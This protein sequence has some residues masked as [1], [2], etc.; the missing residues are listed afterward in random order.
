MKRWM[1]ALSLV[2]LASMSHA[3]TQADLILRGVVAPVLDISI[4]NETVASNLDLSQAASN[5]KVATI[6]EKSNYHQ[7][8]KVKVKSTN[9]GKMVNLSDAN[10]FVN[11][12][13]T[14]SGATVPLTAAPSQVY[15]T[16][17][18]RGTF[19]KELK[20]SYAQPTNLSAGTYEDTVQF[21]IEAN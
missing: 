21:T 1:F 2:T 5:I 17:N 13:L 14:Y 11:Y 12:T 16:S 8:Y 7:G 18:L 9:S 3:A 4:A 15:T 10:S 6:T 19:S 20:I